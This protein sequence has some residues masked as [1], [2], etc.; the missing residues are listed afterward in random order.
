[1]VATD[2]RNT[3]PVLFM[4]VNYTLSTLVTPFLPFLYLLF[5]HFRLYFSWHFVGHFSDEN[6]NYGLHIAHQ[7]ILRTSLR[8]AFDREIET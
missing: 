6:S 1:M 7:R 4:C 3:S 8:G 5:A 2:D